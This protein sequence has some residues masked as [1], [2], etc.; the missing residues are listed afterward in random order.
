MRKDPHFVLVRCTETFDIVR[1]ELAD[2]DREGAPREMR[3]SAPD[4][5]ADTDKWLPYL[6]C[7]IGNKRDVACCI[8][9][10]HVCSYYKQTSGNPQQVTEGETEALENQW[11]CYDLTAFKIRETNGEGQYQSRVESY[12]SVKY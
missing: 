11:P 3:L 9:Y 7:C 10:R 4:Q 8:S 1:V 12:I 5:R 6:G 2:F